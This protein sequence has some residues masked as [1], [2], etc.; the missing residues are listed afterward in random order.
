[1]L[2]EEIELVKGLISRSISDF[3]V[4]LKNELGEEIVNKAISKCLAE[5]DKKLAAKEPKPKVKKG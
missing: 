3:E 2:R 1:M 4:R 5:V